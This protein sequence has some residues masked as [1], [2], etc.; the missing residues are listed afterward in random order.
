M[1]LIYIFFRRYRKTGSTVL[2]PGGRAWQGR[3]QPEGAAPSKSDP[4][5]PEDRYWPDVSIGSAQIV[6]TKG[7]GYIST[8]KRKIHGLTEL[9][10]KERLVRFKLLG[11]E[12]VLRN[13]LSYSSPMIFKMI[14][15]GRQRWSASPRPT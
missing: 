6:V 11:Q 8:K 10:T 9:T 4:L 13:S 12:F 2:N 3:Q 14:D 1:N 15:S 7:Q 5:N